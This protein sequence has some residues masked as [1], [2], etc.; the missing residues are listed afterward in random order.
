MLYIKYDVSLNQSVLPRRIRNHQILISLPPRSHLSHSLL[1]AVVQVDAL[2]E[3]VECGEQGDSDHS[4]API[5][6]RL[7]RGDASGMDDAQDMLSSLHGGSVGA[8]YLN[9][10]GDG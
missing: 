2:E 8:D 9:L 3:P 1:L 10:V 5:H 6:V 4:Q 7:V